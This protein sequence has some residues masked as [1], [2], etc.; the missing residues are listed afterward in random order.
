M[1]I[2][3]VFTLG[4]V[5]GVA[6]TLIANIIIYRFTL[7]NHSPWNKDPGI[8]FIPKKLDGITDIGPGTNIAAKDGKVSGKA[9]ARPGKKLPAAETSLNTSVAYPHN[10]LAFFRLA[11]SVSHR[12]SK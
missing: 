11:T 10:R 5:L 8:V 12:R 1:Y 9:M 6:L 4:I 2:L 7:K 3:V